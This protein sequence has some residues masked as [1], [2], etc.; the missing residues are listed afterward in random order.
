MKSTKDEGS[1]LNHKLDQKIGKRLKLE[2]LETLSQLIQHG[3]FTKVAQVQGVS[4]MAISKQINGLEQSVGEAVLIRTTRKLSLTVFGR[5]LADQMSSVI[6]AQ[7][8]LAHWL[9]TRQSEPQGIVRIIGVDRILDLC[10]TPFLGE[11]ALAFPK[12]QVELHYLNTVP[13]KDLPD[14][15]LAWG[16]GSFLGGLY[17]GLIRKHLLDSHFGIYG[18]PAYLQQFG[19]PKQPMD[20]SDHWIIGNLTNRPS[21][22]LVVKGTD[23]D[24]QGIPFI[25]L[26]AK[27]TTT[28]NPLPLGLQGLGLFNASP[29]FLDIQQALSTGKI[30]E[31][32]RPY[33]LQTRE[34]YLYYHQ[35]R[36]E[37]PKVRACLNFFLNKLPDTLS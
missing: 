36:L 26:K 19:T 32:L 12:I 5:E 29:H 20:L 9:E 11:F 27:V 15:D 30:V 33:W 34:N 10:I 25:E 2:W 6:Q 16:F 18:S 14:F 1:E 24:H 7:Q 31:V 37:Q 21:N 28:G 8:G 13:G 23:Q 35:T 17:P 4:P 3:S 22:I